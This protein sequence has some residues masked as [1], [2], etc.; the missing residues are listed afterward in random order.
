MRQGQLPVVVPQRIS[1]DVR[2]AYL[3]APE[4]RRAARAGIDSDGRAIDGVEVLPGQRRRGTMTDMHAVRV[5]QKYGSVHRGRERFDDAQ[6][7]RANPASPEIRMNIAIRAKFCM[8]V[9]VEEFLIT[10]NS[11][12]TGFNEKG[13]LFQGK[14]RSLPLMF[15]LIRRHCNDC[16]AIG[17]T[18]I[19]D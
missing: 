4:R 17:G 5:Q 18:D 10:D 12:V 8:F 6:Q 13:I 1:R 2:D 9:F 11:T 14:P 7:R 3:F 19:I 16:I 15:Q